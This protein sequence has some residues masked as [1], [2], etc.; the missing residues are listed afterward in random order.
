[1]SHTDWTPFMHKAV[2]LAEQGRFTAAPNPAVG[3]VLVQEG[4]IVAQGAHLEFGG[5]H[6]EINCLEDAAQKG[7]NPA[8]CT[9]V[10]TLEPCCHSGKTPP[11]TRAILAAGI[12]RVVIGLADPNPEAAGG[13]AILREAGLEV[14][15][16]VAEQAC[17]DLLA[18]F[19]VWQ[20]GKRPYV[21]LKLASTLDGRVATR[22]G[23]SQW[24]SSQAS[25]QRVH[26]LRAQ[27]G[28]AG[29]AVLVGGGT[30][31]M[32]NPLLTARPQGET[33]Q[34]QPLAATVSS[35][36]SGLSQLQ[37]IQQRPTQSLVYCS[38]AAA[39]SPV[40]EHLRSLGVRVHGIVGSSRN[41]LLDLN[42]AMIHMHSQGCHY[43]LCE[44]GGKLGLSLLEA[45]LVD[46]FHLHLAP[47]VMGDAEAIP[48]FQG[49][50][51]LTVEE[52]LG[53]RLVRTEQHGPDCHLILRPEVA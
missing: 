31:A 44:G 19:L 32:D 48:L 26:A 20:E 9:L 23:H 36:L 45:G 30:L 8:D 35:R 25:R 3:A 14:V 18:D 15:S 53:M 13:A 21:F 11:C 52:G 50:E 49:R 29:G 28:L 27:I 42:D 4:D 24:I 6:A 10:V 47:K 46:E 39:A 40:A 5:P 33:V 38:A 7:L 2:Q 17:R 51:P 22:T 37:L 1:M 43:V 41:G 12:R 16:G 34:R